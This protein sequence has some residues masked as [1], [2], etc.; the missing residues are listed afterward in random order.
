[1]EHNG[2][3]LFPEDLPTAKPGNAYYGKIPLP[4]PDMPKA[5]H[6]RNAR[7]R[8]AFITHF[9]RSEGAL[10]RALA[11]EDLPT[12]VQCAFRKK[13]STVWRDTRLME[14]LIPESVGNSTIAGVSPE[15][16]R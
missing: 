10:T 8:T 12:K 4:A 14:V 5:L 3:V 6:A 11:G 16:Y 13:P 15:Q 2:S 9:F 7:E 1:M